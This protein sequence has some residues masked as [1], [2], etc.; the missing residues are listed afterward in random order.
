MKD[1]YINCHSS[2]CI[3]KNIYVDPFMIKEKKSDAKI[4]FITHTHFDHFDMESIKNIMNKDTVIVSIKEVIDELKKEGVSNKMLVVSNNDSGVIADVSFE[5]FPSYNVGH[6]HFKELGF[7]GYTLTIDNVRYTICGDSDNTEELRNMKCDVLL[8][9]IGGTY[10]MNAKEAA[11][12]TNKIK[13]SLV[14]PT[15]YNCLDG[16]GTK[17][18]EKEF[19]NLID[20]NIKYLILIK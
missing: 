5:T 1:I 2:I 17:N 10:T 14:I 8:V 19:L 12:L 7:V 11:D 13:P 16:T 9:P 4:I 6:H 15:H 20:R 18:D 3:D